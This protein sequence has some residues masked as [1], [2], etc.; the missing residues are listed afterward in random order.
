MV[1][2]RVIIRVSPFRALITLLMTYL[3][4]PLPLQV[5]LASHNPGA[6]TAALLS[7]QGYVLE[8]LPWKGSIGFHEVFYNGRR[9]LSGRAF[10][11]RRYSCSG[12]LK[13]HMLYN[14]PPKP[15]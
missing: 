5:E 3:L 6:S 9:V 10:Q 11:Y 1:I 14:I 4:S 15:N 8:W 2:S 13:Q 12:L 7:I